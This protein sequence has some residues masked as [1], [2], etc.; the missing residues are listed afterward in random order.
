MSSTA[1]PIRIVIM[2]LCMAL[3]VVI[4]LHIGDRVFIGFTLYAAAALLIIALSDLKIPSLV[5]YLLVADV[6]VHLIKRFVCLVTSSQLTYYGVLMFPLLIY[7]ILLAVIVV[8]MLQ[9]KL[10][11]SGVCLTLYVLLAAIETMIPST[12]KPIPPIRR[13]AT[14]LQS[15]TPVI[16]YYAG[17]LLPLKSALDRTTRVMLPVAFLAVFYGTVQFFSGPTRID[18]VWAQTTYEYSLQ[19]SKV[20]AFMQGRMGFFYG[21]SFFPDPLT[22]GL[23]LCT[24]WVLVR[25][26]RQRDRIGA[27]AYSCWTASFVFGLL[28]SLTRS[29]WLCFLVSVAAYAAMRQGVMRRAWKVML[30]LALLF[31]LCVQGSNYLIDRFQ[32]SISSIST[33]LLRRYA[34][35]GTLSD[36]TVTIDSLVTIL[37]RY[38][39]FGKGYAYSEL[40]SFEFSRQLEVA[41]IHNFVIAIIT[42]TGVPG[43]LLFALFLANWF[44]EAFRAVRNAADSETRSMLLWLIALCFG[45]VC[46]GFFSGPNF[47]RPLF[48]LFAG[49]VSAKALEPSEATEPTEE[50]NVARTGPP[51]AVHE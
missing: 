3:A 41:K 20:F 23:F 49:L 34:E 5:M 46:T 13:Y 27:F 32:G 47:M 12:T 45:H 15:L 4:G 9:K 35:V 50:P 29:P 51:A 44:R 36:R 48:F 33:D 1:S 21:Y 19:G 28:A 43:F 25:I 7:A 22:W 31:P 37:K 24:C 8:K 11:P 10:S 38:W 30:L 18:T 2:T 16:L 14:L 40:Y 39:L 42:F 26:Q 17:Y 6:L